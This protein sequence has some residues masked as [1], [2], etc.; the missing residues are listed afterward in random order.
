MSVF[1]SP[2]QQSHPVRAALAALALAMIASAEP[3]AASPQRNGGKLPLTNGIS[4]VEGATGGGLTTWALIAGNETEDGN[5]GAA[6][7]TRVELPDFGLTVVSGA[8]G[9]RNRIEL[10]VAHQI[11]D[12]RQAGA[13]LGLGR[14]FTFGQDVF[15]IKVRVIGDAE[16]SLGPRAGAG[17]RVWQ[18]EGERHPRRQLRRRQNQRL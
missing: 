17:G 5:G 15:G 2:D 8:I 1:R 9:L 18:G 10:S 3:A 12:T 4:T 14:S 6:Q 7:L 11:F 13:T 16:L